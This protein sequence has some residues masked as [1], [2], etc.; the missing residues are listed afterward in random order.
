MKITN[1]FSYEEFECKDGS[2]TPPEL[3]GNI[4]EL[5]RNLQVLRDKLN[6]PI[7]IVSGYR[8]LL[9]N[10]K[11]GG[12]KNSQHLTGKAADIKVS[13]VDPKEVYNLLEILIEK[14]EIKQGGLGLYKSWV[15][16]DIRGTKARW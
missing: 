5:A 3:L 15:H 1:N 12:A 2:E 6:K 7:T 16:Y 13:G 8:S 4:A 14:G 9:H 10:N 11:V